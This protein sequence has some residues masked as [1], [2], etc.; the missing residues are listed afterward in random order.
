M[1][2]R[3][4]EKLEGP[5]WPVDSTG[6]D[7]EEWK[8][9]VIPVEFTSV[10]AWPDAIDFRCWNCCH[11][12]DGAPCSVATRVQDLE[13]PELPNK[14]N[15]LSVRGVFC[16]WPCA[17][18][19]IHECAELAKNETTYLRNTRI[20]RRL[21]TGNDAEIRMGP[22]REKLEVF[23]GE[24]SIDDYQKEILSIDS[25]TPN[26]LP[27]SI[28]PERLRADGANCWDPEEDPGDPESFIETFSIMD[29]LVGDPVIE[30]MI[31]KNQPNADTPRTGDRNLISSSAE[32]EEHLFG[33][34]GEM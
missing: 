17:G 31:E 13:D 23:G 30:E 8:G 19:H 27:G 2:E 14:K 33:I 24:M 34:L 10:E 29:Y 22:V 4:R 5:G 11:T 15:L 9:G 1:D 26:R 32:L 6:W 7:K 3:I 20:L 18:R 21:L 28:L 16:S 25:A 12:F